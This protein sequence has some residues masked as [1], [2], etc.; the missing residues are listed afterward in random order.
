LLKRG[1]ELE[2]RDLVKTPLSVEEL[3]ALIGQRDY[4]AF[5]NP[6]NEMYRNLRIKMHPPARRKALEL[7]A[8]NPNL[9]R[10]PIVMRGGRLVVGFDEAALSKFAG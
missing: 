6:K 10:R 2:E 1:A 8:K 5:L 9:I 3:D 4:R 7:M